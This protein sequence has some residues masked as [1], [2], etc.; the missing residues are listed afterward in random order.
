MTSQTPEEAF[1]DISYLENNEDLNVATLAGGCFWCMEPPFEAL[2]GV[3]AVISGYSGG[4][5]DRPSYKEVS[6][7]QTSH[8]EAVQIFYNPKQVSY[9]QLL[10]TFWQAHDP[11]DDGGQFADRGKHYRPVIF[12]Q[13][14][15]EETIAEKSKQALQDSRKFDQPILTAIEEFTNFFPAE[16]YHQNYYIKQSPHY[17]RYKKGS[18]REDFLDNNWEK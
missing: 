4:E 2:E 10:D 11:T 3:E 8:T 15:E 12:F 1:P 13:S 9:D 7:G 17:Q 5:E 6:S 18:G 14:E 16:E